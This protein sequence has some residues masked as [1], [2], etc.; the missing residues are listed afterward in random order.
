MLFFNTLSQKEANRLHRSASVGLPEMRISV[1]TPS[2]DYLAVKIV[3][4]SS[5]S[6][7]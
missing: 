1:I 5:V 3:P 6:S 2:L 7:S 4:P